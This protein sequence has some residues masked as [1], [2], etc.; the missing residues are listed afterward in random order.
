MTR[1]RPTVA[2]VGNPNCGKS[3]L[4]NGLTGSDQRVGNWPG[5]TI[6]RKEGHLDLGGEAVTIV[7]LPG[8]YSLAAASEDERVA[9]DYI[10]SGEP[11]LVVDVVDATNLE[12]NLY[13]TTQLLDLGVPLVVVLTMADR[14]TGA[15]MEVD[16]HVLAARLGCPV[17][18]V[19]ATRR[20]DLH[21]VVGAIATAWRERRPSPVI[22]AQR[23]AVEQLA[24]TWDHRLH[25]IALRHGANGRWLA[26][27][28][29]ERDPWA[30]SLAT[31][32]GGLAPDELE[33]GVTALEEEL[34]EASDILLAEGRYAFIES[35]ADAAVVR[36][37]A[38]ET[39]GDPVKVE[40]RGYALSL[41]KAEA[42]AL[43]VEPR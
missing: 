23:A 30:I 10:L 17:V 7:D 43:N 24:A 33:A 34:G 28:T 8:I 18:A 14:A 40:V 41:R 19:D 36:P 26:L 29:I 15:G 13:L 21:A 2:I 5:V 6:E 31:E 38:R 11:A 9:R 1:T 37:A 12:R 16:T 20:G 35:V 32:P 27:K 42:D 25:G 3:T 22:V 39:L 4:F